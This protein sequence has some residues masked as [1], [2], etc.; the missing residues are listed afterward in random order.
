MLAKTF[1][2]QFITP[3]AEQSAIYTGEGLGF[4]AHDNRRVTYSRFAQRQMGQSSDPRLQAI[5]LDG[6]AA[7][8][9]SPEDL[10]A[11]LAG[12]EHWGIFGYAPDSARELV[13]NGVLATM[14]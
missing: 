8:I 13:A 4:E 11:A 5:T 9:Y 7:V 10:T 12:C 2:N 6:R 1:P 3:L 14:R